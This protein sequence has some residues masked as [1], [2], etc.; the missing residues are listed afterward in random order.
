[1]GAA[2]AA[3]GADDDGLPV[4]QIKW[5]TVKNAAAAATIKTIIFGR[6]LA[7]AVFLDFLDLDGFILTFQNAG[8]RVRGSGFRKKTG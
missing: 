6:D 8:Q 3:T 2:P 7:R 5:A 4:S 1:L